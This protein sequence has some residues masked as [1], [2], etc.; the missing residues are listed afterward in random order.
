MGDFFKSKRFKV[1]L[2][3]FVLLLFFTLRAAWTG[4]LSPITSQITS[5]VV[6]PLQKAS[7]A[8]ADSVSGLISR[9]ANAK[10]ITQ[11]NE[12][13]REEINSLRQQLVDY[14]EYEEENAIL[15]EYLGIKDQNP[16]FELINGSVVARD[17]D[18]RAFSFTID[19]GSKDG[20]SLHDPVI[21]P[22]GLVGRV[23]EV[24]L[25]YSKVVTILD[26]AV[27][28][29]AY[30]IRTRNFG[31][32]TGATDLAADGKCKMRYLPRESGVAAGDIIATTGGNIYP[33]NIVIGTVT[34]VRAESGG[35]SLYAVV[36]PA[37]DIRNITDVMV[38]K[39]FD[40]QGDESSEP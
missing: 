11:E 31:S 3:V 21:S 36:E 13:Q 15:K 27:D 18:D 10:E 34:E 22:E 20:V 39:S 17:P 2:S 29:G 1:L 4:G 25:N 35:V 26:V 7:S 24:G 33:K 37:A 38:I 32:V 23:K 16:D 19:V 6:V 14:K 30:D 28:A 5:F 12:A 9:Y 8:I 40:G